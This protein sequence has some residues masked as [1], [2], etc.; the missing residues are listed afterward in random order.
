MSIRLC[1]ALYFATYNHAKLSGSDFV[2]VVLMHP[3]EHG[4][5]PLRSTPEVLLLQV[6]ACP[7]LGG[8][9]Q[10]ARLPWSGLG[11]G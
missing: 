8:T 7:Q 6:L 2:V 9:Q 1:P 5:N 3:W 10:H 11:A 4:R